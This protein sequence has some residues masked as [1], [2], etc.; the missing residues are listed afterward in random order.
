MYM[1]T[2]IIIYDIFKLYMINIINLYALIILYN[3]HIY[4]A[5]GNKIY[6]T[7]H[8]KRLYSLMILGFYASI[9]SS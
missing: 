4:C 7:L 1:T 5:Y 2:T 3:K 6:K 9:L 8:P